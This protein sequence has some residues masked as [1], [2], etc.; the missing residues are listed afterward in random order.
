L[1]Y[2]SSQIQTIVGGNS[3]LQV[4][5][6]GIGVTGSISATSNISGQNFYVS[7]G[8]KLALDDSTANNYIYYYS[9]SP[10]LQF[11]V[12][13]STALSM[14]SNYL[15]CGGDVHIPTN[16]HYYM[17]GGSNNNYIFYNGSQVQIIS[18]GSAIIQ[19]SSSSATIAGGCTIAGNTNLNSSS[20]S[21]RV[22]G[23]QVVGSRQ[24]GYVGIT[25][26]ANRGTSYDTSTITLAQLAQRVKALQD[27]FTTHGLIG[28]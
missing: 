21:Y 7:S 23:T 8:Y 13:G 6:T 5:S 28:A 4:S 15:T 24:T 18:G 17:D 20:Y 27:D 14:G 9:S 19:L 2:S 16:S 22:N 25:G 11:I 3:A 12:S 1:Y 10:S 26:T